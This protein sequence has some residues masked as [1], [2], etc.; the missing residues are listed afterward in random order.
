MNIHLNMSGDYSAMVYDGE[1]EIQVVDGSGPWLNDP[2]RKPVSVRGATQ[3]DIPVQPYYTVQDEIITF[4]PSTGPTNGGTITATFR[5]GQH[6]TSQLVERVGVFVNTT[7]FVDRNRRLTNVTQHERTA[8]QIQTQ[9]NA[10]ETITISVTLPA[11]IRVTRSPEP[12]THVYVRVGV[13][14][15]GV[16]ELA[17]SEVVRLAI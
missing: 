5:V 16:T 4:S 14:A 2:V 9:L 10:N 15:V 6:N 11:D 17:Y 13:K 7:T 8:A 12:R 1:Y 3:F